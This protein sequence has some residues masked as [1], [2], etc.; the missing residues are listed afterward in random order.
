MQ[1]LATFHGIVLTA[2]LAAA[3][4]GGEQPPAPA[5]APAAA[6]ATTGVQ[7]P[8]RRPTAELE[9]SAD[10]SAVTAQGGVARLVVRV[11]LPP[12]LHVQSNQP[13]DAALIPTVLTVTPPEG[14]TLVDVTYPEAIDFQQAGATLAVYPNVFEIVVR[15]KVPRGMAATPVTGSLRYQ[16]CNDVL[17]FGPTRA[18]VM[19]SVGVPQA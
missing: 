4:G 8:T 13:R 19:W 11:S 7:A 6:P 16:A 17:C 14:T 5:P 10:L 3:C 18:D 15:L 1:K 9:T 2:A 12:E